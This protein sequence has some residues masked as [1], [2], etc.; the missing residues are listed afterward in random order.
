MSI[1]TLNL[2]KIYNLNSTNNTQIAKRIENYENITKIQENNS[3]S[4][5]GSNRIITNSERNFFVNLFPDNSKQLMQH[6]VFTYNGKLQ[7]A[8]FEKGSIIDGKI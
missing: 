1:G 6:E 7:K 3:G 2:H 8:G 4:N 5:S